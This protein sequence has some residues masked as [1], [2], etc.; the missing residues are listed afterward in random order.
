MYKP[1]SR[2]R[3]SRSTCLLTIPVQ[4]A[5]NAQQASDRLYYI[6]PGNA[7]SLTKNLKLDSGLAFAQQGP[8]TTDSKPRQTSG[9]SH[10][11][12]CQACPAEA[13]KQCLELDTAL[14]GKI[15]REQ[16][17]PLNGS[18]V[19]VAF[20]GIRSKNRNG[21][22]HQHTWETLLRDVD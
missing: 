3:Q 2:S 14:S 16:L 4:R 7:V 17:C 13:G 19:A 9:C 5:W 22:L 6:S 15:R 18:T 10:C 21:E 12:Y 11:L 20:N 1:Q 8:S